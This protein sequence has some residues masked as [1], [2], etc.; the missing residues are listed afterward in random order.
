MLV[1]ELA[2]NEMNWVNSWN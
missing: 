1:S 2:N